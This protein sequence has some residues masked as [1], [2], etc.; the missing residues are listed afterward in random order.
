MPSHIGDA[1][2]M[3]MTQFFSVPVKLMAAEFVCRFRHLWPRT[4]LT[5]DFANC[6]MNRRSRDHREQAK[7]SVER[8]RQRP[9]APK[10]SE[11]LND[12]A[13]DREPNGRYSGLRS[14]TSEL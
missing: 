11:P 8:L 1:V 12:E 13:E 14:L 4:N 3:N 5:P 9:H 6:L 2:R 7:P 10:A